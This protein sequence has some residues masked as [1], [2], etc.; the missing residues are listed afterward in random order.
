M[1]PMIIA[2]ELDVDWKDVTIEQADLDEAKYGP[3]IA[4]GSTAT[5]TNWDPMRQVGAAG[6]P[7][8]RSPPPRSSWSVPAAELH[9]RRPAGDARAVEP[10]GRLRRAGGRSWRRCTPPDLA[11]VQLKDPK[12]YKI[13]GT[14]SK[15]STTPAIV[16][17]KPIFSIDFTLPGML[18]AVFE[19]CPVFGGKVASANLDEIKAMPGV[20][21]AFVV[22]GDAASLHRRWT[23]R[24]PRRRRDRGRQLVAGANRR[25]TS[26]R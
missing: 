19:K 22:E 7:D 24:R 20:K 23:D 4:G 6:A 2:D 10:V 15:G 3:Q 1:L 9:D 8:A 26:C 14:A 5:P 12:D 21:H 17:G 11:S 25:A 18:Y 16:T 13:I